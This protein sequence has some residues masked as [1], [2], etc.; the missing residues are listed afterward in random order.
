[1]GHRERWNP[2]SLQVTHA[3]VCRGK[4]REPVSNKVGGISLFNPREIFLATS[5]L[6]AFAAFQ[7]QWPPY[8]VFMIVTVICSNKICFLVPPPLPSLSS[9]LFFAVH[10]SILFLAVLSVVSVIPIAEKGL[11]RL[12]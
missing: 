5:S 2:R 7:T 8:L 11:R 3:R 9:F 10:L 6:K 4:Q 1:M 12:G